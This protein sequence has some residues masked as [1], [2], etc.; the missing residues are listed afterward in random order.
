MIQYLVNVIFPGGNTLMHL[1][2][3]K[4]QADDVIKIFHLTQPNKSD[5]RE[6]KY[7]VPFLPNFKG[8]TPLHILV[9]QQDFKNVGIMLEYLK[10]YPIDHHFRQIKD[11]FPLLIEKQIPALLNYL[12]FRTFQTEQTS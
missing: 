6:I 7:Y 1:L 4:R 5:C 11:L 3:E 8:E 2:C 10:G 12:D 9:K